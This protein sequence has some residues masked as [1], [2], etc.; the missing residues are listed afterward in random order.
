ME[1][2]MPLSSAHRR[3]RRSPRGPSARAGNPRTAWC[4]R[5]QWLDSTAQP[6]MKNSFGRSPV[7]VAAPTDKSL[8]LDA[9]S[10]PSSASQVRHVAN[11]AGL[12]RLS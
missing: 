1:A 12:H 2:P 3:M 6:W 5:G 10:A 9:W 7:S 11:S 8:T 4:N